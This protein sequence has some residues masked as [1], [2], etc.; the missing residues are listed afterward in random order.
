MKN[1]KPSKKMF[2]AYNLL[3]DTF[4][5]KNENRVL[6]FRFKTKLKKNKKNFI[7]NWTE[8]FAGKKLLH[9][10][11]FTSISVIKNNR[12]IINLAFLTLI[13][14]FLRIFGH[15]QSLFVKFLLGRP[16]AEAP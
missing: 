11:L 4:E 15:L 12:M 8:K 13:I 3:S 5:R 7:Y 10:P 9:L 16:T 2:I 6:S 14:F 1:F